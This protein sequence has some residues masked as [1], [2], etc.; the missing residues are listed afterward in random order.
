MTEHE[1]RH[2]NQGIVTNRVPS[3][4]RYV[5]REDFAKNP[6]EVMRHAETHGPVVITDASG[7]PRMRI[8]FPHEE[9]PLILD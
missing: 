4:P 6:S 8:T 1:W 2:G 3:E 5:R 7:K 9:R